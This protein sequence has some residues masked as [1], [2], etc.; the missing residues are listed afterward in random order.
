M[1]VEEKVIGSLL[2]I[3]LSGEFTKF[4]VDS[5]HIIFQNALKQNKRIVL[6]LGFSKAGSYSILQPLLQLAG[7]LN[8]DSKKLTVAKATGN[9]RF[10]LTMLKKQDWF[11]FHEA[12]NDIVL[13]ETEKQTVQKDPAAE[14]YQP[15]FYNVPE[16]SDFSEE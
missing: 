13:E 3:R 12:I 7:T 8:A 16:I 1:N 4:D 2:L 15:A 10:L 11:E 14:S 9:L 5:L 6:E